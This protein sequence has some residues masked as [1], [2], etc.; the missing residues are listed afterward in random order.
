VGNRVVVVALDGATF[1]LLG[2]WLDAGRLPNLKMMIDQGVSGELQSCIPPVTA[3]AWTSFFTG[4]NPGKHGVFDFVTQDRKSYEF[5]PVD[6]RSFHGKTLWEVIGDQGKNVAVLNV[7]MTHPAYPVKGV[8]VSD[9]LLATARG[10]KSHPPEYLGEIEQRFGPYPT[11]TVPPY[12]AGRY[13][14]EDIGRFLQ[15]YQQ[16]LR[17]KLRVAR[18]LLERDPPDFLMVHLFGNDQICHWLWHLLDEHHPKHPAGKSR[19]PLERIHEYYRAFDDEVGRILEQTGDDVSLFIVSDHGFGPVH[20]SIDFNTWLYEEGY[21]V[22]KKRPSTRLRHLSWQ[23][24]WVPQA[25]IERDWFVRVAMQTFLRFKKKRSTGN[26]D[27]LKQAHALLRLFLSFDDI[28]WSRTKAFSPFGFG[29]IRIN[30]RER[31]A[32][33]CVSEGAEYENTRKEIIE[34]LRALKDPETGES[35]EGL[36]L[37]REDV[38]HGDFLKEAPDILFIPI[39]GNY[40]PKS[41]GFSSKSVFSSSGWMTGIHKLAGVLIARGR[42]LNRGQHLEGVR[43][44]DVFPSI[45]GLMGLEIPEDVDGRIPDRMFTEAFL[46][47]HP[48]RWGAA[49]PRTTAQPSDAG[50]HG[51][52]GEVLERLRRLGYLE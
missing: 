39:N 32:H 4:K 44:T 10:A 12:F 16:A 31:W 21:L 46:R 2:P 37:A 41:T 52:D 27:D 14:D 18:H 51:E 47:A 28:D 17:Y 29:Q 34:K 13:S 19:K 50:G 42:P 5:H 20:R 43:I 7:P 35:P 45:L 33:G 36:V 30:V 25:L 26:V 24:G 6:S 23:M 15:E 1:A 49:G 48:F 9:F 40:R 22:L 3:P 38:Y 11:E 8:L